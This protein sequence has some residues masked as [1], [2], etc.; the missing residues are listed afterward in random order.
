MVVQGGRGTRSAAVGDAVTAV[1]DALPA[2]A[3]KLR[4]KFSSIDGVSATLTG[5]QILRLAKWRGIS[6]I[7]PDT[8]LRATGYE[9]AEMW[10]QTSGL[11]QLSVPPATGSLPQAPA[12]AIIDSGIDATRIADFGSRVVASVNV[13]SRT[14]G[15]TGDQQGHGTMVAGIAAGASALHPVRRRTRS[16]ST[17]ERRRRTASRWRAT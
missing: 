7:T 2:T 5:K 1:A 6:A 13:S 14:P 17:S 15:A 3:A 4:R 12:I 9:D 10:R 16:S 8:T 11:Q